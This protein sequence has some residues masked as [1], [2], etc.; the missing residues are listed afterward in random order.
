MSESITWFKRP[1][2][3]SR[4]LNRKNRN[5]GEGMR[6][7]RKYQ[8][9]IWLSIRNFYTHFTKVTRKCECFGRI[10]EPCIMIISYIRGQI[11]ETS[12]IYLYGLMIII[13]QIAGQFLILYVPVTEYISEI[14]TR[15]KHRQIY[16]LFINIC[17]TLFFYMCI[18]KH[19]ECLDEMRI[20]F[21]NLQFT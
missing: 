17:S 5:I 3:Q 15:D 20:I 4:N 18:F 21:I 1:E 6:M 13:L 7:F 10:V 12:D 14:S 16:K 19:F 2:N 9:D 11:L 8:L